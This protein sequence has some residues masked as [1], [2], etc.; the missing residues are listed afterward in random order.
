MQSGRYVFLVGLNV[1]F[2]AFL[3]VCD[4]R[5]SPSHRIKP[6]K[7]T[8]GSVPSMVYSIPA[9]GECCNVARMVPD[10]CG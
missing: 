9:A 5:E 3:N 4:A 2:N 1:L 10:I 7:G 8:L 6:A